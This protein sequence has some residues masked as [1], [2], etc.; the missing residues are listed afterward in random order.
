MLAS[1]SST[2]RGR[3]RVPSIASSRST[4]NRLSARIASSSRKTVVAPSRQT[5]KPGGDFAKTLGELLTNRPAPVVDVQAKRELRFRVVGVASA[6]LKPP[7]HD[8]D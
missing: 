4:S 1:R 8:E 6:V 7:A 5:F 3:G 2:N